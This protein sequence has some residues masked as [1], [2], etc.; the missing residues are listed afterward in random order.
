MSRM[1]TQTGELGQTGDLEQGLNARLGS[2]SSKSNGS[3]KTKILF[4]TMWA[5]GG[6]VA[7]ANAMQQAIEVA[8]PDR[9]DITTK[10]FIDTVGATKLDTQNKDIW[11]FALRYP[12]TARVGQRVIDFW[13]QMSIQVQRRIVSEF[14]DLAAEYLEKEK[15][16]LIISNYG[17]VS[18][19]LALAKERHN[20]DIDII[21][22]ATETHNICAYWADPW[23]DHIIVPNYEL[24]KQLNRMGVPKSKLSVVGYPV[25]QSFLYPKTKAEAKKLFGLSGG[26]SCLLTMG[27]EGVAT[28]SE[29]MLNTLLEIPELTDIIVICGRNEAL[30]QRLEQMDDRLHVTG[31]VTNMADYLAASDIVIGKAGPASVYETL[32]V[33]RPM[34]ITSYAGL[35]ELGVLNFVVKS[36][37]GAYAKTAEE[38]KAKIQDYVDDPGELELV[39]E[40]CKNLKLVDQTKAMGTAIVDYAVNYVE[41]PE[42]GLNTS[43]QK[44]SLFFVTANS[45]GGHVATAQA[46]MQAIEKCYPEKFDFEMSDL[47][48][49]IGT[50]FHDNKLLKLDNDLKKVWKT[51]LK[52]PFLAR[53]GQRLIESLPYFNIYT[54]RLLLERFAEKAAIYFNTKDVDLIVSNHGW[55]TIGLT[56][57]QKDYGMKAKVLSFLT[58]PLDA[59]ALWVDNSADH[60][61]VP[62]VHTLNELNRFGISKDRIDV[63]GYPVQ[64]PMID[65]KSKQQAREDL[66]L[67][68]RPTCL[69]SLGGEGVSG[70]IH[71]IV[72]RLH[73][74]PLRPQVVVISGR[75]RQLRLDLRK[76]YKEDERVHI[77]GYVQ[78]MADYLAACDVVVGNSGQASVMEALAVGRPVIV[79]GYPGLNE[80]KLIR[81][82]EKN[83]LGK[84]VPKLIGLEATINRFLGSPE[85]LSETYERCQ[86]IG[87]DDM[88]DDLADY[89]VDYLYKGRRDERKHSGGMPFDSSV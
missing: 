21:T 35:N 8:H 49:E 3:G 65:A 51:A 63:V 55:L 15:P 82:L 22:F 60:F 68:N 47:I 34:V 72:S 1:A 16:D 62:S 75:N 30:K 41:Q 81:F 6:H 33:G 86:R 31:F 89:I 42:I 2:S 5:G 83:D 53:W 46:M 29:K 77:M 4:A 43:Q 74:H 38:L 13:P 79:T 14:A 70:R 87:L 52:F 88:A 10:D 57:A 71:E 9:F 78:N 54:H 40:R 25:Q 84:Y 39:Q 23:A 85:K 11:R 61:V 37:L 44:P 26:L 48:Y 28:K 80:L 12:V 19:G 64:R 7:T 66:G 73:K 69:V 45:G 20:L 17:M 58:E 36:Q 24:K 27:G 18:S 32:A 50:R 59:S 67:A 56:K 76:T